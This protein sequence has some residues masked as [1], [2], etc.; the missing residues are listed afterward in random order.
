MWNKIFNIVICC[1]PP[2]YL[3]MKATCPLCA[4]FDHPQPPPKQQ[5]Q[6]SHLTSPTDGK[7]PDQPNRQMATTG[8]EPP[9]QSNGQT[10]MMASE[11][12]HQPNRHNDH[13]QQATLPAQRTNNNDGQRA[14]PPAQQTNNND[15]WWPSWSMDVPWRPDGD[16]T[17]CRHCP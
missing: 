14:T 11:P 2:L 6:C 9:H 17:C 8:S 15:G 12:P 5:R 7:P 3:V 13:R 1:L 10:T 16:D 4:P